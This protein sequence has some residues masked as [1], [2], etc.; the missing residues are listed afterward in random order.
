MS[1]KQ[2]DESQGL[3]NREIS[4]HVYIGL[5]KN[6]DFINVRLD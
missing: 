3:K 6:L 2:K 4:K 5:Q 1:Q